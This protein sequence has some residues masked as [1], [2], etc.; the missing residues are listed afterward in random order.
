MYKDLIQPKKGTGKLIIGAHE[1]DCVWAALG[2]SNF[3]P[4]SNQSGFLLIKTLEEMYAFAG[5]MPFQKMI[6]GL[7][8]K[9]TA[10]SDSGSWQWKLSATRMITITENNKSVGFQGEILADRMQG[11]KNAYI[12]INGKIESGA[13]ANCTVNFEFKQLQELPPITNRSLNL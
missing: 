2:I 10:L 7:P 1:F 13:F 4:V 11:M 5:D 6:D 9:P 12:C 3:G 8:V